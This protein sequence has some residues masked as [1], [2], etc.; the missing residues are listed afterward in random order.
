MSEKRWL[1]DLVQFSKAEDKN[2]MSSI[3]FL[4]E[5]MNETIEAHAAWSKSQSTQDAEEI[6]DGFCDCAFVALSGLRK[7]LGELGIED[8]RQEELMHEA[9]ARVC[10]ANLNK[11]GPDG[12]FIKNEVGKITKPEGWQAPKFNDFFE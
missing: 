5:E 6:I 11:L 10:T 1:H 2:P 8:S 7:A 3:R 12:Q 9:M 4:Q